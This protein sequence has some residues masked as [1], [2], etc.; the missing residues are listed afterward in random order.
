MRKSGKGKKVEK[1]GQQYNARERIEWSEVQQV[2]LDEMI[3]HLKS[4][5]VIAYYSRFQQAVL[6]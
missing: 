3:D 2:V 4:L 5:E 1:S 6:H